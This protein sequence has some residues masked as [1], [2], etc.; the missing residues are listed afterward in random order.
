MAGEEGRDREMIEAD[1]KR[2]GGDPISKNIE[3]ILEVMLD[4]RDHLKNIKALLS[5]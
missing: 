5:P 4:C 3:L 2:S 1:V